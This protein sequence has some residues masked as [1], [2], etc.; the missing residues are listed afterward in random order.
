MNF[1]NLFLITF[2][3][4]IVISCA[5]VYGMDT[6][7]SSEETITL[8][9]DQ[10]AFISKLG[11]AKSNAEYNFLSSEDREKI[12]SFYPSKTYEYLKNMLLDR[13][14]DSGLDDDVKEPVI[15]QY[16]IEYMIKQ[17]RWHSLQ[18]YK[19]IFRNYEELDYL[20]NLKMSSRS[21]RGERE[22]T[23]KELEEAKQEI[24]DMFKSDLIESDESADDL[25]FDEYRQ[26]FHS[27]IMWPIRV[28]NHQP[29][30]I[31]E[32]VQQ[33]NELRITDIQGREEFNEELKKY[34]ERR[35]NGLTAIGI[36]SGNPGLC[37]W[38]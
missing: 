3:I 7:S 36:L 35:R 38:D 27:H 15:K 29:I 19:D 11:R 22:K 9:Q 12:L 18:K 25:S 13:V 1:R 5:S 17:V 16:L 24:K 20:F 30:K 10:V 32:L 2:F 28:Y 14:K 33:I 26:L 6:S 4:G 31:Q 37:Q 34:D 8:T 23:Q 21:S